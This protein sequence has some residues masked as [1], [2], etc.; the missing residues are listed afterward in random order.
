MQAFILSAGKGTR[1]L[2]YTQILPK[3]L[4]PILGKPILKIIIS[5]LYKLGIHSIG[6]NL[7]H[8]KEKILNFLSEIQNEFPKLKIEVFIEKELLGTGGAILNAKKFFLKEPTLLINCDILTN[9]PLKTFL[10]HFQKNNF[11]VLMLFTKGSN[12]NVCIDPEK[13]I[14]HAFRTNK[15]PLFSFTGIQI[16]T[17]E[18]VSVLNKLPYEKDLIKLYQ[19][20]IKKI[21][22]HAYLDLKHYFKDIGTINNYLQAHEDL[23]LKKI[24]IPEIKVKN[25][26]FIIKT[27]N[28][29]KNI[30]LKNWVYI[31]DEVKI[32]PNCFL[33]RIVAWKDS[34]I[35][36]GIH[37]NKIFV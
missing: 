28:I 10:D 35:P 4:F 32:K 17:P 26:P 34:T 14:V 30:K 7:H 12:A 8:L 11:K 9:F 23:I 5:S 6:I 21:P 33:S 2:P 31:E 24:K 15:K 1:L 18:A 13:E 20:L 19:A 16:I 36:T 29:G 37:E 3:P 27:K 22:V 25:T